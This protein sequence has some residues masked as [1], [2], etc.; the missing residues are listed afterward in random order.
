[1]RRHGEI[2]VLDQ[3]VPSNPCADQ[4]DAVPCHASPMANDQS[5]MSAARIVFCGDNLASK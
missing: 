4:P 3:P 2:L 5:T 1:L